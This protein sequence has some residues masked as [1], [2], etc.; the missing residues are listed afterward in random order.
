MRGEFVLF[1]V[2]R[3]LPGPWPSMTCSAAISV[4]SGLE[5]E[6][7]PAWP[8]SKLNLPR[9]LLKPTVLRRR[10]R[11]RTCRANL[12]TVPVTPWI[13]PVL[14]F[15]S[16]NATTAHLRNCNLTAL[17]RQVNETSVLTFHLFKTHP[18]ASTKSK[19]YHMYEQGTPHESVVV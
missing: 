16:H 19:G 1:S 5:H 8:S 6:H 2:Y 11:S 15:V 17:E 4:P 10:K 7:A 18:S 14:V 3:G 9:T 13:A 12:D